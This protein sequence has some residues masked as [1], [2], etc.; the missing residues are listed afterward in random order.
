M[1]AEADPME[2]IRAKLVDVGSV[3]L[4]QSNREKLVTKYSCTHPD[5]LNKVLDSVQTGDDVELLRQ[6][7]LWAIW[8]LIFNETQLRF[9][10][11]VIGE[12]NIK[13][14]QREDAQNAILE[15]IG[16]R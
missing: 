1:S 3:F 12:L 10:E 8:W 14:A 16:P 4:G 11:R 9:R 5:T 7:S 2:G 13:L 6:W 15:A